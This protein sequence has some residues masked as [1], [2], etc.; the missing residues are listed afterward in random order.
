LDNGSSIKQTGF[1]NDGAAERHALA[2][3]PGKLRRLAIKEAIEPDNL[4]DTL[5]A[6]AAF[7]PSYAPRTQP[8]RDVLRH[9]EMWEERIGLEHHRDAPLAGRQTRH[10][11]SGNYDAA[12]IG[13]FEPGDETERRRFAAARGAEQDDELAG[14]RIQRNILDGTRGCPVF[15]HAHEGDC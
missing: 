7:G 15:R 11:A 5:E 8:E 6:R 10:I 9:R 1:C 2:L 4:G 12:A 14:R 3:P 13:L